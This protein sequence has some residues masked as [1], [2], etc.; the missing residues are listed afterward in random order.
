MKPG[1]KPAGGRALTS[2]ERQAR[3]RAKLAAGAKPVHYRRPAD[4]RTRPQ[5]WEDAVATLQCCLDSYQAWR[6]SL[7]ENLFKAAIGE[8]LDELLELREHVKALQAAELP[9]GFGRD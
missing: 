9:R 3:L 7:P 5:Q 4:R 8:R 1:P 2:A 6:N